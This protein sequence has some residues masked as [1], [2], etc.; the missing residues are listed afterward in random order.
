MPTE[1][2]IELDKTYISRLDYKRQLFSQHHD[3]TVAFLPGSEEASFEALE[4]LVN[5]LPSRYPSMFGK[6]PQGIRNHVTGENWDLRRCSD[7]WTKKKMHPLEVMGFLSTED[8][9][10]MQKDPEGG[11]EYHLR[12]GA[13]CFPCK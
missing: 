3:E 6:T 13:V 5:F 9:V 11:D 8:W 12:A 7:I 10:I 4:M 1:G 2:W